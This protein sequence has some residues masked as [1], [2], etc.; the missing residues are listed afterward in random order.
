M[1]IITMSGYQVA[2]MIAMMTDTWLFVMTDDDRR[3]QSSEV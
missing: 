1:G 3:G 2:M